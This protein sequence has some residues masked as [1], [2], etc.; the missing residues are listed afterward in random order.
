MSSSRLPA[1]SRSC[2]QSQ[3]QIA[4]S[5]SRAFGPDCGCWSVEPAPA[6]A[7]PSR[8]DATPA[9]VDE[10]LRRILADDVY[11]RYQQTVG[12]PAA[13]EAAEEKE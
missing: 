6:V 10:H 11:L 1:L 7:L 13:D 4:P 9:E 5:P 8:F 12:S 2:G 3:I